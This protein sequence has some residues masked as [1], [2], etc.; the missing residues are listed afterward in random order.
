M[1]MTYELRDI[2][3]AIQRITLSLPARFSG[4]IRCHIIM[5]RPARSFIITRSPP[6]DATFLMLLSCMHHS[7]VRE[8]R[9]IALRQIYRYQQYLQEAWE[10]L[11]NQNPRSSSKRLILHFR[12]RP[13]MMTGEHMADS[14]LKFTG[15]G[16]CDIYRIFNGASPLQS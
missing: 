14:L 16:E 6:Y 8:K 7:A 4:R 12:G 9:P 11:L 10:Y 5:P 2:F 13:Y 1:L 3:S 15:F